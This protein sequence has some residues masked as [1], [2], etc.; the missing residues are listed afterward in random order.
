MLWHD[1]D[2]YSLHRA[3]SSVY[4]QLTMSTHIGVVAV[5]VVVVVVVV[6]LPTQIVNLPS[7][8]PTPPQGHTLVLR[9]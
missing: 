1:Q 3:N 2:T 8:P 5:V 4:G 9:G 7:H 6:S